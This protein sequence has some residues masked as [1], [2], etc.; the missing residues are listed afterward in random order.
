MSEATITLEYS[1]NDRRRIFNLL[2]ENIENIIR[3]LGERTVHVGYEKALDIC[4]S[5]VNKFYSD[6]TPG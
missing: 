3:E 2:S 6:Y 4:R 1:L 5:T